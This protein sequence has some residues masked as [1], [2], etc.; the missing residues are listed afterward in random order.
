M[1]WLLKRVDYVLLYLN[2]TTPIP[3][4]LIYYLLRINDIP[5]KAAHLYRGKTA[6][7]EN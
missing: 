7:P 1:R 2:R 4:L 3:S 5:D 6:S